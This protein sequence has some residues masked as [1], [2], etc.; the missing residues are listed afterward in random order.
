LVVGIVVI[1]GRVVLLQGQHTSVIARVS[2][3]IT[4]PD[5]GL[6]SSSIVEEPY[7][8]VQ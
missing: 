8:Q 2:F 6:P 3:A 7:K 5:W 4:A 1:V